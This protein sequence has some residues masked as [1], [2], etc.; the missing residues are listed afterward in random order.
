[1]NAEVEVRRVEPVPEVAP[2]QFFEPRFDPAVWEQAQQELRAEGQVLPGL[3]RIM[4]RH[5][6]IMRQRNEQNVNG[7][8]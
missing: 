5:N 6:E 3:Q 1:M 8:F 7:G 4:P 2:A